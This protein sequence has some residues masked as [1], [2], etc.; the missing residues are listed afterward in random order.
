MDVSAGR[1]GGHPAAPGVGAVRIFA[2]GYDG[3]RHRAQVNQAPHRVFQGPAPSSTTGENPPKIMRLP[4]NG[5]GLACGLRRPSFI[6]FAIAA[7]RVALSGH[8]I[9]SEEHTSEL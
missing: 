8:S 4:K 5:I 2:P 6:T 9:R 1:R 7:S 3:A